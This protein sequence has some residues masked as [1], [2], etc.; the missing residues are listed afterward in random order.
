MMHHENEN[1]PSLMCHLAPVANNT[2]STFLR[3]RAHTHTHAV[4]DTLVLLVVHSPNVTLTHAS[5]CTAGRRTM[6][7]SS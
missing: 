4:R 1:V 3:A 7:N 6:S 5:G 2:Q